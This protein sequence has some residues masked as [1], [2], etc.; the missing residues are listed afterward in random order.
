MDGLVF[1]GIVRE[2]RFEGEGTPLRGGAAGRG[3][4]EGAGGGKQ[5][6]FFVHL[7]LITRARCYTDGKKGGSIQRRG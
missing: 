7:R 4:E 5:L 3:G 2:A 1:V 6:V